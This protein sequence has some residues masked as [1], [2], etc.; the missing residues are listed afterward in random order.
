MRSAAVGQT[1]ARSNKADGTGISW[2]GSGSLIVIETVPARHKRLSVLGVCYER[3]EALVSGVALPTPSHRGPTGLGPAVSVTDQAHLNFGPSGVWAPN[4]FG[5]YLE[6]RPSA[7][8][9]VRVRP[10]SREL[11]EPCQKEKKAPG[12]QW[13]KALRC[14]GICRGARM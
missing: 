13:V 4:F 14:R 8:E 12:G 3:L 6:T 1:Q 10:K 5:D 9:R 2:V 7:P 11:Q